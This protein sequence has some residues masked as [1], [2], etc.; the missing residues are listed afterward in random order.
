MLSSDAPFSML[1]SRPANIQE[2]LNLKVL[3]TTGQ[4]AAVGKEGRKFKQSGSL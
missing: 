4:N 1:P 3:E 2:S